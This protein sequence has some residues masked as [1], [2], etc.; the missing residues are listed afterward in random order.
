ML[1]S[2]EVIGVMPRGP[3]FPDQVIDVFILQGEFTSNRLLPGYANAVG[4]RQLSGQ[5]V[6][7][8]AGFFVASRPRTKL[9]TRADILT[10]RKVLNY[11]RHRDPTPREEF[12]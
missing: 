6:Q 3:F 1:A 7:S 9:A 10:S 5:S 4:P 2:S 8:S 12:A 11:S